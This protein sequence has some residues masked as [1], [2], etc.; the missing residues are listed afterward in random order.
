MF[1]I[2]FKNHLFG[3]VRVEEV[4]CRLKGMKLASNKYKNKLKVVEKHQKLFSL[5][6]K[7]YL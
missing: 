2:I 3:Q 4:G 1:A 6:S 5:L 7:N